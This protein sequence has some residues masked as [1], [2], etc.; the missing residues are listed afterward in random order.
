M[1]GETM[2]YIKSPLNYVGGKFKLLPQIMPLLPKTEIF[3][4][5][6]CGGGNVG[7]NSDASNILMNDK[8]SFVYGLLS[9]LQDTNYETV[10]EYIEFLTVKYGLTQSHKYGVQ[11]YKKGVKDNLGLSRFNK[12]PYV[13][14]RADFNK[15]M[16]EDDIVDYG[17]FFCIMMFA[18]NNQIRFNNKGEYN[19]PVG[20]SDFNNSLHEKVKVFCDAL[21]NKNIM[22]YNYDFRDDNFRN[23][24]SDTFVY[25]DIP[26][27][28]TDA[29]YNKMWT[30]Q[31]ERDIYKYLDNLDCK[32]A[33]SNVFSTNGKT[34]DILI[35]WANKYNVH[36]LNQSY[37]NSSYHRK[38]TTNDSDE[39]LVC[40]Y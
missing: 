13:K 17:M 34:N 23:F 36:H 21:K 37:A 2:D 15:T 9:Y 32:W 22:L 7:I 31:D 29:V 39:V 5:L 18:F 19:M 27:I 14:M 6:F 16:L 40:N 3:V 4:D 24:S 28:I 38:N 8:D 33:L 11:Y 25:C 35:E 1:K 12:E 26:Y 30:E 20:K 10:I